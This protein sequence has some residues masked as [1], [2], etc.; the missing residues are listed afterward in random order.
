MKKL[1]SKDFEFSCVAGNDGDLMYYVAK[2]GNSKMLAYLINKGLPLDQPQLK[3]LATPLCIAAYRGNLECVKLLINY[4]ADIYYESR[5]NM[6]PLY[7][8]AKKKK[9]DVVKYLVSLEGVVEYMEERGE[10]NALIY[11]VKH[12][13]IELLKVLIE[14]NANPGVLSEEGETPLSIAANHNNEEIIEILYTARRKNIDQ[15]S[16]KTHLTPFMNAVLTGNYGVADILLQLECNAGAKDKKGNTVIDLAKDTINL[17]AL[18]YL[19]VRGLWDGGNDYRVHIPTQGILKGGKFKFKEIPPTRYLKKSNL[20]YIYPNENKIK[21][22]VQ[23]PG[24]DE[25][26][27]NSD[28]IKK[29]SNNTRNVHKLM[30]CISLNGIQE[31]I[32]NPSDSEDEYPEKGKIKY[33]IKNKDES[34]ENTE[35]NKLRRTLKRGMLSLTNL[36][37]KSNI[38]KIPKKWESI[39]ETHI[40]SIDYQEE[41]NSMKSEMDCLSEFSGHGDDIIIDDCPLIAANKYVSPPISF[42]YT[43]DEETKSMKIVDAELTIPYNSYT[44][45]AHQ[46]TTDLI[47]PSL[48]EGKG[49]VLTPK[50]KKRLLKRKLQN[51]SLS[52]GMTNTRKMYKIASLNSLHRGDKKSMLLDYSK[53]KS[54]EDEEEQKW[55]KYKMTYKKPK[56]K[57]DVEE[58]MDL[59]DEDVIKNLY[60]K[61]RKLKKIYKK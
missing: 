4:G 11:A 23:K 2:R 17:A 29:K 26:D 53:S 12:N 52:P 6:T 19:Q 49:R 46:I 20:E 5:E 33:N 8:A 16:P 57:K 30:S 47:L 40:S 51:K 41:I 25:G 54:I 10:N 48:E 38:G 39:T 58:S 59:K 60:E 44:T 35:S 55:E 42:N 32:P 50:T 1:V 3:T 61:M 45:R 36:P 13:D 24:E 14:G 21:I 9:Y 56:I 34:Y 28:K 43:P 37:R 27:K 22:L 15:P 7:F 31:V 18:K